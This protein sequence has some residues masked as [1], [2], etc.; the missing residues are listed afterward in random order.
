[1]GKNL[2]VYVLFI[3]KVINQLNKAHKLDFE[4][5]SSAGR[6]TNQ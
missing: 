4:E 1:M 3:S 2:L 6:A 5:Y